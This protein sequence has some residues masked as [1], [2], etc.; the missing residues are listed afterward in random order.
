MLWNT[1]LLSTYHF[2]L[3]DFAF[4]HYC[5][6]KA[7]EVGLAQLGERQT[8]DLKVPCSIHGSDIFGLYKCGASFLLDAV[9]VSNF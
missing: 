7:T 4:G 6:M 2:T 3:F 5:F 9:M 1:D 8:E